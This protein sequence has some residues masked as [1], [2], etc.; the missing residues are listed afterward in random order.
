MIVLFLKFLFLVWLLNIA[1]HL[2][3]GDNKSAVSNL[4]NA[5][6]NWTPIRKYDLRWRLLKLRNRMKEL[7]RLAS[8]ASLAYSKTAGQPRYVGSVFDKVHS[9]RLEDMRA[10]RNTIALLEAEL[11]VIA[12]YEENSVQAS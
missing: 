12:S 11:E 3:K 4:L 5:F 6:L 10:V 2:G 9:N 7:D 8:A 1:Y